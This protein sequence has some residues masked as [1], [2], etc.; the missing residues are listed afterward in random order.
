MTT[1]DKIRR[2]IESVDHSPTIREISEAVGTSHSN[3]H[4]HLDT[5]ETQ[6]AIRRLGGQRRIYPA[7]RE[8]A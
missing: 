3:V 8:T 1:R 5:L 7:L 6:G 2:Y 4:R